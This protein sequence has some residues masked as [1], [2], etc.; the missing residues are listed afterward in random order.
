M[1]VLMP[2]YLQYVFDDDDE[3]VHRHKVPGSS[4]SRQSEFFPQF[5]LYVLGIPSDSRMEESEI[6]WK[7]EQSR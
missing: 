4:G 5:C 6:W 2:I 7:Y 3:V 1:S